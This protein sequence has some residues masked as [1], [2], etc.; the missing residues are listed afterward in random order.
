MRMR[1]QIISES[2]VT[3]SSGMGVGVG[4]GVRAF[5][6][7][8]LVCTCACAWKCFTFFVPFSK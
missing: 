3:W 2:A 6:C 5:V 8:Y 7:M 1:I 4:V